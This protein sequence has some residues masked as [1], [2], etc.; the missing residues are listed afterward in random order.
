MAITDREVDQAIRANKLLLLA[1][2][3]TTLRR[4]LGC[5]AWFHS[6][7]A[8]HRQCNGCK[9]VFNGR[10]RVGERVRAGR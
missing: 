4:C 10:S 9:R 3:P 1:M 7:G 2:Q 8:D 6:T 5:E